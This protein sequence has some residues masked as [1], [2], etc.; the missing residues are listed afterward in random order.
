MTIYIV[1]VHLVFQQVMWLIYTEVPH[2][3]TN[4]ML[5]YQS[6]SCGKISWHLLGIVDICLLLIYGVLTM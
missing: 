3:C 6:V 4:D 2:F 5:V 1:M